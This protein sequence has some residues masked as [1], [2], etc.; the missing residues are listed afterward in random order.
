MQPEDADPALCQQGTELVVPTRVL[1]FDEVVGLLGDQVAFFHESEAVR[2]GLR[3][4]VFDL[5]HHSGDADFKEFV[6]I[7]GADGKELEPLERRIG[8]ILRLLKDAAIEGQP[9][10][11]S[12]DVIGRVVER[13]PGHEQVCRRPTRDLRG[14]TSI[15][16][17]GR[18]LNDSSVT[19]AGIKNNGR[20]GAPAPTPIR[21]N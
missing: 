13:E 1:V 18:A 17:P 19:G 11:L 21:A 4:A 12:I 5:L 15:E 2:P 8:L 10:G 14:R 16:Q 9:R 6:Q 3:V 7:A 20:R